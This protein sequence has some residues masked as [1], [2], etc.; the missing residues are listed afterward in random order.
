MVLAAFKVLLVIP[1]GL[2]NCYLVGMIIGD[3]FLVMELL[4]GRHDCSLKKS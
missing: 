3:S 2:W 1:F 4:I